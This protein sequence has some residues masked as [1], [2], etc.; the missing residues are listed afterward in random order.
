MLRAGGGRADGRI[1]DRRPARA[2]DGPALYPRVVLVD[3]DDVLHDEDRGLS[4]EAGG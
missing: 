2:A 4:V 1:K 3:G